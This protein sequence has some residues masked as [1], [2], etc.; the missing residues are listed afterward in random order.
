MKEFPLPTN[1]FY[2]L[3]R[4]IRDEKNVNYK[5]LQPASKRRVKEVQRRK[6]SETSSTATEK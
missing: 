4:G 1:F 6:V 5:Q 3:P 2:Y